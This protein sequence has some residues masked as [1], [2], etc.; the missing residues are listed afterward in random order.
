MRNHA[1]TNRAVVVSHPRR[2]G[3]TFPRKALA[4]AAEFSALRLA[5]TLSR[6]AACNPVTLSTHVAHV[7][8]AIGMA[9]SLGILTEDRAM[10]LRKACGQMMSGTP[11]L[12][13]EAAIERGYVR[14]R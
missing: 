13:S 6:D 2:A 4:S 9:L 3:K 7:N 14:M 8:G 11:L 10:Q 5:E 12:A 1:N